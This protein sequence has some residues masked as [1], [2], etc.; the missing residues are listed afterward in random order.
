MQRIIT[1][2]WFDDQAE[3]AANFYT[4]LFKN[5]K[6]GT[7]TR[8]GKSAAAI[9]ARQEGSVMTVQFELDGQ[10]FFALNGGP[11]FKFNEAISLLVN[12][13]NQAELDHLWNRLLEGGTA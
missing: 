2:L 12:C 5:S 7:I 3:A 10:D 9:A 13:E 8:Y 6:I 4:S 11:V 1:H